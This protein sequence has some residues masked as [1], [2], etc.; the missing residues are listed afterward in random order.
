M[1]VLFH[2]RVHEVLARVGVTDVGWNDKGTTT[3][4]TNARCGLFEQLSATAGQDDVR[5]VLGEHSGCRTTNAGPTTRHN[6]HSS[7]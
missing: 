4:T 5:S 6:R 2:R 3:Q 7:L 1:S